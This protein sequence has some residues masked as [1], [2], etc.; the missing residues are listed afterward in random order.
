MSVLFIRIEYIRYVCMYNCVVH[1]ISRYII[2]MCI[3]FLSLSFY[4][5]HTLSYMIQQKGTAFANEQLYLKHSGNKCNRLKGKGW[6]LERLR[7]DF[8]KHKK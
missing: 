3:L 7:A 2:L 1:N 8:I 5:S 6:W 4:L